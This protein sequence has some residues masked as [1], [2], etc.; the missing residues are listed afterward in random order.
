MYFEDGQNSS[1]STGASALARALDRHVRA[2][3]DYATSIPGLTLHRR[4]A[5]SGEIKC[6][7][8][9]GLTA[10]AQGSKRVTLMDEIVDYRPGQCML[11]T[12]DL[13][14]S[15]HISHASPNEPFLALMYT[16]DMRKITEV[17]AELNLP[18]LPKDFSC[19]PVSI[20]KMGLALVDTLV[21]LVRCLDEP[22]LTA[23]L[24]P[25]IER[26]LILRLLTGPQSQQLRALVA[27]GSPTQ[28]IAAAVTWLKQNYQNDLL[29][30][31][32]AD[33][34]HMSPSTFR[35]HFRA[36]TGTTP[37]QYQKQLRLQEAR[38]LMLHQKIDASRAAAMVGYESAS[39]F[40]REYSR[41]FGLPPQRDIRH[42]RSVEQNVEV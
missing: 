41:F 33:R 12:I 9:L 26:E 1:E 42:A 24:Y 16:L 39:Q 27:V 36:V 2:S 3:G 6:I 25:L 14:I 10:I 31:E 29:V 37:V 7:Y 28:K 4:H 18:G 17:A 22:E 35:H 15:S 11:T 5:S 13:P 23:H 30:D 34:S 20:K 21:R 19:A 32:L 8:S 38:Q 40:S